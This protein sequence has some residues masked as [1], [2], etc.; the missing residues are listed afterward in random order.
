MRLNLKKILTYY[1]YKPIHSH[2]IYMDCHRNE[3]NLLAIQ[4]EYV[5]GVD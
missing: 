3:Q 1:G 4:S 5:A 2:L